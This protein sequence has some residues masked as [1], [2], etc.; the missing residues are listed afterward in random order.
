M[1]II[2]DVL[3]AVFLGPAL[4]PDELHAQLAA[5]AAKAPEHLDWESSIV[6]LLK[7]IEVDSSVVHRHDIARAL[8]YPGDINDSAAMNEW[9]HA[10]VLHELAANGGRVPLSLR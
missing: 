6:D 5:R 2:A 3:R 7:L 4:S 9:L 1:S 8:H 10:T